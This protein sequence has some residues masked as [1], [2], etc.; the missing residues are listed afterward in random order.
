MSGF[1]SR[2]DGRARNLGE[3]LQRCGVDPVGLAGERIGQSLTSV[4]RACMLCPHSD[5]CRRWLDAA[6]PEAVNPPPSFCPNASR[7]RAARLH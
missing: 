4:A 6:D 3:M 2:L 5:A 7:I 1:L